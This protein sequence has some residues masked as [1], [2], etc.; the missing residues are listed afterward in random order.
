MKEKIQTLFAWFLLSFFVL[1]CIV[2][3]VDS[4]ITHPITT[5]LI[6]LFIIFII[7]IFLRFCLAMGAMASSA[8]IIEEYEYNM[9]RDCQYFNELC[10][11][12]R[13]EEQSKKDEIEAEEK[14]WESLPYYANG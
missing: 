13:I 8:Q 7:F 6:T 12:Y 1:L 2:G 4:L 14:M 11:R 10:E 3:F 5:L 9:N